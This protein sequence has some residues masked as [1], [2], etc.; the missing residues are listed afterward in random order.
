MKNVRV[1]NEQAHAICNKAHDLVTELLSLEAVGDDVARPEPASPPGIDDL[2]A[3]FGHVP[4]VVDFAALSQTVGRVT[5]VT[6]TEVTVEDG[7]RSDLSERLRRD[8]E[9]YARAQQV[10]DAV[11]GDGCEPFGLEDL[12]GAD[13][14]KYLDHIE[15][16][17]KQARSA[18]L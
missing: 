13:F 16:F 9:I 5:R 6:P 7:P 14:Q 17:V 11:V 15:A 1:S 4:S 12:H 3:V 18:R 2:N 8:R 10:F